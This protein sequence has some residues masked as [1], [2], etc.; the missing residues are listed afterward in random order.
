MGVV[1]MIIVLPL[2]LGGIVGCNDCE[3][4]LA[5][6]EHL[7]LCLSIERSYQL[8]FG[9]FQSYLWKITVVLLA[10]VREQ[11]SNMS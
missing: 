7:R 6:M 9:N 5:I 10:K 2:S 11:Q 8:T 3:D 4:T 1:E